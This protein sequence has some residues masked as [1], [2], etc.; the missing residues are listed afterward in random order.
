MYKFRA[1]RQGVGG[2]TVTADCD[3]RLIRIGKPLR[4]W[5]LDELPQLVTCCAGR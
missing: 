3:P 4:E 1:M 2:L 5:S